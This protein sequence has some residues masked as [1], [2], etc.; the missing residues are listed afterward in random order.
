MVATLEYI[1]NKNILNKQI[2]Q[3]QKNL[4]LSYFYVK[5]DIIPSLYS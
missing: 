5:I 3:S 4:R 2:G 1:E